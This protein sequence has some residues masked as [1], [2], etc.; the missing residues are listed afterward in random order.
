[1][2]GV[3][4]SGEIPGVGESLASSYGVAERGDAALMKVDAVKSAGEMW[5]PETGSRGVFQSVVVFSNGFQQ[6]AKKER[7]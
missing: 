1:M 5:Y 6:Y 4:I 7:T 3:V 2:E